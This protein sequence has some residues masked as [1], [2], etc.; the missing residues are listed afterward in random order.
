MKI[1]TRS[2]RRRNRSR[3][4][5]ER[6]TCE[7]AGDMEAKLAGDAEERRQPSNFPYSNW[8]PGAA[9]LGLVLAIGVG[10]MLGIPALLLGQQHGEI[11]RFSPPVYSDGES[12]DDVDSTAIA[13]D[14]AS[15]IVYADHETGVVAFKVS[16][17]QLP[18]ASFGGFGDSQG[19][20]V[21][22][23]S[24][25]IYVS[26]QERG[27][28]SVYRHGRA[29]EA[30]QR[31][32][33]F[34]TAS[35][36]DGQASDFEPERL[37]VDPA[38]GDVYVIDRSGDAVDR[39]SAG[40]AF[41][42]QLDAADSPAGE[43]D[44]D[45]SEDGNDIAVD[46]AGN[47]YVAVSGDGPG[48]VWAFARDGSLLWEM[49]AEDDAEV[50]GVGLDS[51]GR[52]WIADASSGI[53]RY[54]VRPNSTK[55]PTATGQTAAPDSEACEFAFADSGDL[56]VA[57]EGDAELTTG[58]S[59]GVQIGTVL[60][61]LLVPM[62]IA[63]WRGAATMREILARLGV[64]RFELSAFKWIG[65]AIGAYLLF[66]FLYSSL[67]VVPEQEDIAKAFGSLPVQILLI[68]IAAPI[69]EEICFRGMLFGG[70]REKLPRYG[71][72]LI[73]AVLFGGLH[74]LTGIT[75]VPPLIAFGFVLALLY[76]KTGSIVPCIL[77]HMLNNS[78]AL[79][80][81]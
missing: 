58:A 73:A 46:D 20:A 30:P 59:V 66:A 54:D 14:S 72:A 79:L 35:L 18:D 27:E 36:P 50:C 43:F 23:R 21:D 32:N 28:V 13:V 61:F 76:E 8:G 31:V 70:L 53:G 56:F 74:A 9:I 80:A 49:P 19:I 68:A 48:T 69:S 64:R 45:G 25:R 6:E 22:E 12:F 62:A 16:G 65:A 81:Q 38:A 4:L 39:F 77:L 47:V 10:I 5:V 33:R 34:K 78:V 52:L 3:V 29:A 57:R 44:F 41:L 26:D 63:A 60:G 75:A 15:G 7:T 71:A 2:R 55:L 17:Q 37:A 42:G 1:V 67:I 51:K 11:E 40:G 24:G